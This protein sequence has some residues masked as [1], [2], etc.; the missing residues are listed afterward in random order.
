MEGETDFWLEAE[1]AI[2]GSSWTLKSGAGS[3]ADEFLLYQGGESAGSAPETSDGWVRYELNVSQ[4]G[5]YEVFVRSIAPDSSSDSYWVRANQGNWVE[6]NKVNHPNYPSTFTWS[7]VEQWVGGDEVS[8]VSFNLEAGTN[9]IDFAYRESGISMDKIFVTLDGN[10][11]IGTGP[12]GS[13]CAASCTVGVLCDDGNPCT[14]NDEY[15]ADCNCVGTFQDSDADGICDAEDQCAGFDDGLIGTPCDDGDPNTT[16]DV[17]TSNCSCS[18]IVEGETD[19]WLEAECAIVGSSWTLKSGAGSSADEFLLYQGGESAGSAP[20]TSDGWV[21]Y[22]LNVSQPGA[23]EVF[24]RSIAPDS[25][26]D[27]YWVRANQ[28]N[29]VEFNKVNHPNY[30]ST[31]TWSQVEQWVG[32]D[33]VSPVSFNLEAGTNTIDFAYRESGISMDKIFV[34]LDG[35][36]PADMGPLG[37]NCDVSTGSKTEGSAEN[38]LSEG[39]SPRPS[40]SIHPNPFRKELL[41]HLNGSS[42]HTAQLI[43]ISG[44]VIIQQDVNPLEKVIRLPA[45]HLKAAAGLYFVR[46]IARGYTE[47]HKVIRMD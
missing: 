17:Y 37:S 22:E 18:G 19:F 3:S 5:A 47:T 6:F 26:S 42:F 32:G 46:L 40:A 12:I 30:P 43:D 11:P 28:G 29:W 24:V 7:Q 35:S 9:T 10:Q 2:V 31:F 8:P 15:D 45:R 39:T 13:N 44:Q 41:I 23:Y 33:E 4:P 20:E 38:G 25:S 1:C 34:T 27:S 36:L 14:V 16:N 21:R